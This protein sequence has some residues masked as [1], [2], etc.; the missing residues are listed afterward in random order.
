VDCSGR[1]LRQPHAVD[2]RFEAAI[3]ENAIRSELG[4]FRQPSGSVEVFWKIWR[5]T[6]EDERQGS[7]HEEAGVARALL[8]QTG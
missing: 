1:P 3:D 4:D 6:V 2:R 7:W 5:R 8:G